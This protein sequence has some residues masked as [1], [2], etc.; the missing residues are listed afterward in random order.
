MINIKRDISNPPASL[1]IE[2]QKEASGKKEDG[3]YNS[4]DVVKQ[5]AKE[6]F[7]KCYI[8]E[9]KPT[10]INI[11]HFR[12]HRNKNI[13]LKFDPANLFYA[14][15][16]CNNCKSD[17]FENILNCTDPNEDVENWIEYK[18]EPV[19][20]SKAEFNLIEQKNNPFCDKDKIEETIKLLDKVYNGE[21]TAIKTQESYNLKDSLIDEMTA[22]YHFVRKYQKNEHFPKEQKKS[23]NYIRLNLRSDSN[24]TAFKR[25]VIKRNSKLKTEFHSYL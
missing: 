4:D 8:C 11:E 7:D 18:I 23:K 25:W 5:I 24:F 14:C 19:K 9:D 12:P 17:D 10:S 1:A 6:F 22:F 20:D 16:H 3:K 2:K 21:H 13:D 15:T